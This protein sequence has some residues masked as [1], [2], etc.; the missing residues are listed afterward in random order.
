MKKTALSPM[1]AVGKITPLLPFQGASPFIDSTG[2]FCRQ[3]PPLFAWRV[4]P[5]SFGPAPRRSL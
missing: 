3:L 5:I 4:P 1:P 2:H